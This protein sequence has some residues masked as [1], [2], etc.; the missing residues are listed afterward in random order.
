MFEVGASEMGGRS[1]PRKEGFPRKLL[2]MLLTDVLEKERAWYKTKQSCLI[3]PIILTI[4]AYTESIKSNR[5][6]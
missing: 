3:L 6:L 2:E 4:S 1:K 5:T